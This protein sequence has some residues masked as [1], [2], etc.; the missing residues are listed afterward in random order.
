MRPLLIMALR[1]SRLWCHCSNCAQTS[2]R[3]CSPEGCI[4]PIGHPPYIMWMTDITS[5]EFIIHARLPKKHQEFK[6][7]AKLIL[8]YLFYFNIPRV[9]CQLLCLV[10]GNYFCVMLDRFFVFSL[11][12]LLP[13]HASLFFSKYGG[14]VSYIIFFLL[15]AKFGWFIISACLEKYQF[16]FQKL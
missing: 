7:S 12:P 16:P 14:R 4:I 8:I 9:R 11:F 3:L 6:V 15:L 13:T 10:Y 2:S 1:L 5:S